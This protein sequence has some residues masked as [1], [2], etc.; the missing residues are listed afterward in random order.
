MIAN[1]RVLSVYEGFFTGGARI[2]HSDVV[3]GLQQQGASN[4]VV[5]LNEVMRRDATVQAMRDN[6]CYR[7]LTA[8]GVMVDSLRPYNDEAVDIAEYTFAELQQ[9]QQY[10]NG[11]DVVLSLK[12]QPLH[13]INQ[14]D[15]LGT[16]VV[17]CLHRSDPENQ[18]PALLEL[19]KALLSGKIAACICCA[20]STRDA[21]FRAG[22]SADKLHVV[23]NGVNLLRFKPS[24]A[25][26]ARIR[27]G[28]G[29]PAKAP[30]VVFAARYDRM[31]S[32]PPFLRSAKVYLER[33]PQAHVLMCGSG[34]SN[35]N[36]D[37]R[38]RLGRLFKDESVA[39]RLHLL[40]VQRDTEAVY[41]ASDVVALTSSVGEA[42]PL[43]L[44]EGMM[45]G[46]IPVSTDVGDSAAIVA[47]RGL[48]VGSSANKIATAWQ[49]AYA[50]REEF[51]SASL[52]DRAQFSRERMI[53]SYSAVLEQLCGRGTV[54]DA[55]DPLGPTH[56]DPVPV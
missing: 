48:I 1:L 8:A 7:Y 10:V 45:C 34:M 25:A 30:V 50:R 47:R 49:E 17:V 20:E 51:R 13:L 35:E 33:E 26:R 42:Y 11:A 53:E 2:L 56:S 3:L 28:L 29:I 41:A 21:Y 39:Q 38:R 19:Q 6:N 32:V 14:V 18:G 27:K 4:F 16:P 15:T 24:P 12:E 44:I 55:P 43:V 5:S 22:I 54:R 9:F 23:T 37:L 36:A 46:A 40:S 52:R 31:K